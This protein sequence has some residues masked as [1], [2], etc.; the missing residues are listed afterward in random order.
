MNKLTRYRTFE[1]LKEPV[2]SDI[3]NKKPNS[4]LFNEYFELINILRKSLT[5]KAK[6]NSLR[7]K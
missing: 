5:K 1:K 4:N 2:Y 3:A 7:G 6:S